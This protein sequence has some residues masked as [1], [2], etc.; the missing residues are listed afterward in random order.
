MQ[1]EFENYRRRVEREKQDHVRFA[2]ENIVRS[3]VDVA[4]N[5]E[6]ALDAAARS[7]GKDTLE[8]MKGVGMTLDQL[9]DVLEREGLSPIEAVGKPFDPSLHE[10]VGMVPSEEHPENVVV[11]ECMKGYTLNSKVLRPA[12]VEVSSGKKE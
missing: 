7:D 12:K 4:E 8:L 9:K 2:S 10:A 3:L 1:A 11:R 6:R 5:L